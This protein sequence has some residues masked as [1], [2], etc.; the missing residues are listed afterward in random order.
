MALWRSESVVDPIQM[1]YHN[2]ASHE[3]WITRTHRETSVH[4]EP[5]TTFP[6]SIQNPQQLSMFDSKAT[7]QPHSLVTR[8][9]S[10]RFKFS[11]LHNMALD[12]ECTSSSNGTPRGV[13]RRAAFL[14]EC[15]PVATR[16]CVGSH[17]VPVAK[18]FGALCN[19]RGLRIVNRT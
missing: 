8:S 4:D 11:V 3:P 18:Y 7:C 2:L 16:L 14:A 15:P 5:T 6:C 19:K 10:C 13:T 17:A 1:L 12:V 9:H